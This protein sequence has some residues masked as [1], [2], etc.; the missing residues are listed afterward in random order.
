MKKICM[1]LVLCLLLGSVSAMAGTAPIDLMKLT[2]KVGLIYL[3]PDGVKDVSVEDVYNMK[4]LTYEMEDEWM[5]DYKLI[6]SHSELLDGRDITD[7]TEE[8]IDT[9]VAYTALDSEAYGYEVIKM[10]D[11]WP[12]ILISFE[13]TSDW[14]DAVTVISGY[15][16]QMHGA[17][18]DFSPL[19]KEENDFAFDLLDTVDIVSYD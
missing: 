11:G 5:P 3:I 7:L 6:I 2:D 18:A 13:G 14:V 17:H 12:A 4:I 9:L 8:E 10:E 1:L 19:T 15:I 16:I